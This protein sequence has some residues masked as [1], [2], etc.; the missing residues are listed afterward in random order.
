M[1]VAA[2]V[3][4]VFF[5]ANRVVDQSSESIRPRDA[6]VILEIESR[7]MAQAEPPT[8]LPAEKSCR[9]TKSFGHFR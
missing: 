9:P 4:F 7:G 8:H 3:R 2:E 6:F 1:G 5:R